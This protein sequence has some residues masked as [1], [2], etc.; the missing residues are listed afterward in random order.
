FN[1]VRMFGKIPLM[2]QEAELLNPQQASV[3]DIYNQ[4]IQDLTDAEALPASYPPGN[5]RGRATN[6]AAKSILAKVYL[7]RGDWQHCADLCEEV[8]NSGEYALWDDFADVFKL[9]SRG[10]KEAIFSIGFGD[11]GGQIIFWEVGQFLVRLLPP[12][13]SVEG[14]QNA[15]GWDVPTQ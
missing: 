5:G 14:V 7:T 15:Q 8:I 13:L 11:A 6:G 3:D 12:Q 4:I 1:M 2:L 9:S 10:G